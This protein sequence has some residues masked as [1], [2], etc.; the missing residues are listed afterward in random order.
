MREIKFKKGWQAEIEMV[1]DGSLRKIYGLGKRWD[2][3]KAREVVSAVIEYWEILDRQG[4]PFAISQ[5]GPKIKQ[6]GGDYVVCIW[7]PFLGLDCEDLVRDS[8]DPA[9]VY[10]IYSGLVNVVLLWD[11]TYRMEV[12]PRDFVWR[13]GPLLV[14][15]FPPVLA[16][17][18]GN[19]QI[20]KTFDTDSCLIAMQREEVLFVTGSRAGVLTNLVEHLCA[21]KPSFKTVFTEELKE[22]CDNELLIEVLSYLKGR[23]S[24]QKIR[25]F[26]Q[27]IYGI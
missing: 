27:R 5:A 20:A 23:R 24:E 11:T 13:D 12:K 3:K 16:V 9:L 6:L 15:T 17:K 25:I 22:K 21:I 7:Q 14:D 2:E 18:D 19:Y 4:L 26:N 8:S 10:R 1:G